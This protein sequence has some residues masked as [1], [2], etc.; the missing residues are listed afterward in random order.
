MT[1]QSCHGT[2]RC[3]HGGVS[4]KIHLPHACI[5]SALQHSGAITRGTAVPAPASVPMPPN[6]APPNVARGRNLE[7]HGLDVRYSTLATH[8]QQRTVFAFFCSLV[9]QNRQLRLR[10]NLD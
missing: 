9:F 1:V 6:A 7:T 2:A 8:H 10:L 3:T 5:S 4:I